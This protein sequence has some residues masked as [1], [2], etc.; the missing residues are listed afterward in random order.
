MNKSS[1][2]MVHFG[3]GIGIDSGI[4]EGDTD[5]HDIMREQ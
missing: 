4:G 2:N 1:K 3:E 5:S